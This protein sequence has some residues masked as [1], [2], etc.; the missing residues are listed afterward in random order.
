MKYTRQ[1]KIIKKYI[2]Y[3]KNIDN[4]LI[5]EIKHNYRKMKIFD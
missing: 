1:H 4:F 5:L 2:S 3:L